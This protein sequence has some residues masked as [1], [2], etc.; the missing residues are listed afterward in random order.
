MTFGHSESGIR[1]NTHCGLPVAYSHRTV[2]RLDFELTTVTSDGTRR[3]EMLQGWQLGSDYRRYR[4]TQFIR[5]SLW[6][7]LP[8][9]LGETIGVFPLLLLVFP[10]G[11]FAFGVFLIRR[12]LRSTQPTPAVQRQ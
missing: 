3:T 7:S 6:T 9:A 11:T 2:T 4:A 8:L 12:G 10:M 1:G 5:D